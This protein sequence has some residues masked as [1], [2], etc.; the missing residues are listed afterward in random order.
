MSTTIMENTKETAKDTEI[1]REILESEKMA[2][3]IIAKAEME[4]QR[5]LNDAQRNSSKLL[6]EKKEGI[7][8]VQEKKI[9]DFMSKASSI[10][11]AK[12]ADGKKIASQMK[13]KA[14]KNI[15]KAVDF[16]MKK[17]EEMV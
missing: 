14:E 1:L 13:A 5:I 9:M 10:K 15:G 12:I 2:D 7:R 3:E 11:A 16:V 6:A 8:R 17:L 4:K